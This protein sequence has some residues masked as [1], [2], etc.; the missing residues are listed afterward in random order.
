MGSKYANHAPAL[1]KEGQESRSEERAA[2]EKRISER[3]EDRNRKGG[4]EGNRKGHAKSTNGAPSRLG[5]DM[6]NGRA[7]LYNLK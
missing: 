7:K 4:A 1:R 3:S 2:E 6:K 5:T